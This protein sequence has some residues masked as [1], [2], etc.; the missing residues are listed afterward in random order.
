MISKLKSTLF[1]IF[2]IFSLKV[3]SQSFSPII[4]NP[5]G[6]DEGK[7]F[8]GAER[9]YFADIDGDGDLDNFSPSYGTMYFARNIGNAQNP[10]FANVLTNPFGLSAVP[11]FS[12]MDFVDIDNDG[13]LDIYQV[14][15][16]TVYF[17]KNNGTSTTPSFGSP[18]EVSDI[19]SDLKRI[20]GWNTTAGDV[21]PEIQIRI[22]FVDIDNDGD[23]DLFAGGYSGNILFFRNTGTN[24]SPSFAPMQTNPF[25]FTGNGT[26]QF[27]FPSFADIDNDGDLDGFVTTGNSS[28]GGLRFFRN[29]GSATNPSFSL[30]ANTFGLNVVGRSKIR[31]YDIDADGDADAFIESQVSGDPNNYIHFQRNTLINPPAKT[32]QT[33]SGFNAIPTQNGATYTIA[34]VTGGASGNPVIFNSTDPAIATVSGNVITLK[35]VGVCKI[36]ASQVGNATFASANNVTQTLTIIDNPVKTSQVITG[37]NTIPFQPNA[38]VNYTITGVTGGASGLPIVY[39]SSDETIA[40][41]SGNV[42]NILRKGVVQITASQGG[43]QLFDPA[44]DV[45]QTL[46]IGLPKIPQTINGFTSIP[47]L[48]VGQT[49]TITGVTGGASGNPI[50]YASFNSNRAT[51]SGNVITATGAGNVIISAGQAGNE[52]YEDATQVEVTLS[53]TNGGLLPQTITGFPNI[54]TQRVGQTY[55]INGVTGGASG[56]PVVFS[57]ENIGEPIATIAGN[58]ITFNKAGSV[59]IVANQAGNTTYLPANRVKRTVTVTLDPAKGFQNIIGFRLPST[60]VVGNTYTITGVTGGGSGNPIVYTSSNPA[61]ASVSGNVITALSSGSVAI[62]ANQAGNASFNLADTKTLSLT[63]S[64]TPLL[65]QTITGFSA[66]PNLNIGQTYTISGVTG[67]GSG[68]PIIFISSN[69]SIATV[70]ENVITALAAGNVT[71]TASQAG[72]TAYAPAIDISQ[73]L[74]VTTVLSTNEPALNEKQIFIYPNPSM[75][76][77]NIKIENIASFDKVS[78]SLVDMSGKLV[79]QKSNVTSSTQIFQLDIQALSKGTYLLKILKDKNVTTKKIIIDR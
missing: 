1:G 65:P 37:F 64:N 2:L 63:I 25:G 53:V 39:A 79:L 56:N 14:N 38:G 5:F 59:D 46:T 50:S 34:G 35:N 75:D 16:S 49:Y 33:I 6:L 13:D 27:A 55:I 32:S 12:G 57:I 36:I 67:G 71:I 17:Y 41:I 22:D 30:Q 66:I 18:V 21:V 47:S 54:P 28:P 69:P 45:V 74:T 20:L 77:V 78:F 40:S 19:S 60:L 73:N 48:I 52:D 29:T 72:N 15:E 61:V 8:A 62:L 11:S 31:F 58:I 43:N 76:I 26:Y 4:V 68:N 7:T 23:Q 44:L 10:V 9:V 42:I 24:S 70:S 51:I 3:T